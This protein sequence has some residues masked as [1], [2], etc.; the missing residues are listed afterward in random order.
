M[1]ESIVEDL[2]EKTG[3]SMSLIP[4][5]MCPGHYDLRPGD[6][7]RVAESDALLLHA[8]QGQMANITGLMAAARVPRN[9][10]IS[11][12]PPAIG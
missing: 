10:S 12:R 8:F 9:A 11:S 2:G 6:V 3:Q 1:L 4:P 7:K 5:A